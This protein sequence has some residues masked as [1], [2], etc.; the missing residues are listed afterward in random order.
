MCRFWRFDGIHYILRPPRTPCWSFFIFYPC[1]SYMYRVESMVNSRKKSVFLSVILERKRSFRIPTLN[2][3]KT[4]CAHHVLSIY[5]TSISHTTITKTMRK[6]SVFHRTLKIYC[7]DVV[8]HVPSSILLTFSA[9]IRKLHQHYWRNRI[10][11][12]HFLETLWR[13]WCMDSTIFLLLIFHPL[14]WSQ[15]ER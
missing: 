1:Y 8:V 15:N 11:F 5:L 12:S 13:N 10:L 6:I 14:N 4:A 2:A 7:C 3:L 9:I